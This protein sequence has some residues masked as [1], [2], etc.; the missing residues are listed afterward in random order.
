MI[1][2]KTLRIRHMADGQRPAPFP[3]QTLQIGIIAVVGVIIGNAVGSGWHPF[4]RIVEID[5]KTPCQH[6][7][8][9]PVFVRFFVIIL[10]ITL[11]PEFWQKNTCAPGHMAIY[12]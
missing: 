2:R 5:A 9:A 11:F 4:S 6:E 10:K 12:P 3:V 1:G 7:K 8:R